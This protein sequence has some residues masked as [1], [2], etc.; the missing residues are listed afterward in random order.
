M[1]V[2]ATCGSLK[3]SELPCRKCLGMENVGDKERRDRV[4]RGDPNCVMPEVV[5]PKCGATMQRDRAAPIAESNPPVI[6]YEC[7][8]G[9]G[10]W[11]WQ[12]K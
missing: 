7:K 10:K 9:N 11:V 3:L 6:R 12:R 1:A 2:C 8:C 4:Y 5:C